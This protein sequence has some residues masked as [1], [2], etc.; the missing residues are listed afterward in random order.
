MA[1]WN[2][3]RRKV[4]IGADQGPSAE[5]LDGA[6]GMPLTTSA[7]P[8]YGRYEYVVKGLMITEGQRF[9]AGALRFFRGD[10]QPPAIVCGQD[11]F[12][13]VILT[14]DQDA[15]NSYCGTIRDIGPRWANTRSILR[16]EGAGGTIYIWPR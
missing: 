1:G 2:G 13:V 7:A 15:E 11:G 10:G 5:L 14:Y 4:L 8:V 16:V 6:A 12:T 3:A 9:E